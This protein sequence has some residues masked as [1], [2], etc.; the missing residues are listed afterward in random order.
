MATVSTQ[1]EETRGSVTRE[2]IPVWHLSLLPHG[3][4]CAG[5]GL[6]LGADDGRLGRS[7]HPSV[8]PGGTLP[9]PS[10]TACPS[11]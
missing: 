11:T 3:Q 8:F 9:G 10:G 2:A 6:A 1:A 4:E 7:P 5:A